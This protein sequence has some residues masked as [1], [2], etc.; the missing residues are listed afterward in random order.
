MRL[1]ILSSLISLA[2]A[3]AAIPCDHDQ[4]PLEN[5]YERAEIQTTFEEIQITAGGN[6]GLYIC[7]TVN[8]QGKCVHF[9]TP[10][11]RCTTISST[12]PPGRKGGVSAAGPDPGSW[13]TLYSQNDC[14]GNEL[15]L[16]YPGY[17]DLKKVDFNERAASYNCAA[18]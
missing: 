11:G 10:F 17:T 4:A 3:V 14:H 1:T 6:A 13:C 9:V 18:E 7:D 12:F 2:L 8:F 5:G 16:H 15:Q